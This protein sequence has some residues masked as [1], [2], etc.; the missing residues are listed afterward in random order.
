MSGTT[1]VIVGF[2]YCDF[3]AVTSEESSTAKATDAGSDNYD[4]SF[5]ATVR[6]GIGS[7]SAG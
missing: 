2:Y 5:V 3:V 7:R 1:G 6:C 4:I